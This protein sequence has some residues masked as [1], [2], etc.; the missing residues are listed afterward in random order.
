M[1]DMEYN[2]FKALQTEREKEESQTKKH[3]A[4]DIYLLL[5][6]LNI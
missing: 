2:C 3:L 1:E 6:N 4:K 5:V